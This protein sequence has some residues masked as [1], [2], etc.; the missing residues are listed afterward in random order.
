M[1]Q[2]NSAL[3]AF[4]ETIVTYVFDNHSAGAKSCNSDT[5][6]VADVSRWYSYN[7]S[8]LLK[9]EEAAHQSECSQ[10]SWAPFLQ[11]LQPGDHPQTL[12]DF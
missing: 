10:N 8:I 7:F 1:I 5:E 12:L 2:P 6:D 11:P 3:V 9:S 4:H